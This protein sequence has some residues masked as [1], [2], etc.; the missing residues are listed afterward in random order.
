MSASQVKEFQVEGD[1]SRL[2]PALILNLNLNLYLHPF[3]RIKEPLVL[4]Q[5]ETVGHS[6]DVV[7]GYPLPAD[8]FHLHYILPGEEGRVLDVGL[9][10][11]GKVALG[12][13]PHPF[14]LVVPVEVL[15]EKELESPVLAGHIGAECDHLAVDP[16]EVVLGGDAEI[17]EINSVVS[18]RSLIR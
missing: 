5:G 8:S 3:V 6:G 15:Q 4:I 7:A 18:V 14:H 13:H 9:E 16:A 10:E 17:L 11:V 1:K 2:R 12:L